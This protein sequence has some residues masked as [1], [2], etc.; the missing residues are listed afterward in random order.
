LALLLPTARRA[1][2]TPPD[3]EAAA[4]AVV[5][6]QLVKPLGEKEARR[7]RFSRSYIPPQA[8]QVRVLDGE[9]ATDGRGAAFVAFAVDERSQVLV[10]RGADDAR[11]W[12]KDAIV[13]CVYPAEGEVFIKR[14]DKFFAARLLLGQKTAADDTACRPAT[15]RIP[16][17]NPGDPA[18][19][20]SGE[21]VARRSRGRAALTFHRR[22]GRAMLPSG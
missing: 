8:R 20:D 12:R 22:R 18:D 3:A 15:A 16:P 19:T 11:R 5:E 14:G 10:P 7:N 6:K 9:R 4:A 13:G 2:A 1:S 17:P 21:H